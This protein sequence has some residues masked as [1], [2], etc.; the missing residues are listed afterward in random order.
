MCVYIYIIIYIYLYICTSLYICIY[1]YVYVSLSLYIYIYIYMYIYIY[2]YKYAHNT[3]LINDRGRRRARVE[4][5]LGVAKVRLGGL[6]A[7]S[8][9]DTAAATGASSAWRRCAATCS[10]SKMILVG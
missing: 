8:R 6:A 10:S 5:A 4:S 9:A 1:I 3:Y 2:I 7:S